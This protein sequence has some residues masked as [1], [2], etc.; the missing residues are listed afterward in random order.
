[1]KIPL[2]LLLGLLAF[3][4]RAQ[5]PAA[6]EIASEPHHHLVLEN[7]YV[8]VWRFGL[9]AGD[10]TLLH[11]HTVNCSRRV[12]RNHALNFSMRNCSKR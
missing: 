11:A 12:E 6:V 2:F 10:S 5:A 7:S 9:P 8:R 4:L 3:S 1:M